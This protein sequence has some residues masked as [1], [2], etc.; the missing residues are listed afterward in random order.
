LSLARGVAAI[1]QIGPRLPLPDGE[2]TR[3]AGRVKA[4]QR[5]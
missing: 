1:W 5:W 4:P 3:L 2:V